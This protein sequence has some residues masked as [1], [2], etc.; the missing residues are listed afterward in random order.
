MA[1]PKLNIVTN[2]VGLTFIEYGIDS[3]GYIQNHRRKL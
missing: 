1:Y 2:L 3:F